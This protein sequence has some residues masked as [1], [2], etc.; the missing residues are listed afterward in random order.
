[1]DKQ[2]AEAIVGQLA[3]VGIQAE[4]DAPEWGTFLSGFNGG[5]YDAALLGWG[6][7]SGEPDF[8]LT[9]HFDS[10]F[11]PNKYKSERVDTLLEQARREFDTN[12]VK[13]IYAD[14]Q[15]A[16]WADAPWAPLYFQPVVSGV[17]KSLRGYRSYPS[18]YLVF[19]GASVD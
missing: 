8:I 18:E 1:M 4:L 5:K 14:A 12:A 2:V 17:S 19:R 7:A 10:K 3:Q 9:L 15:A 11:S 6:A 16:V 13:K